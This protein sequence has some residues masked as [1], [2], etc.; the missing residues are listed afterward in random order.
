MTLRNNET[1]PG[2]E[3]GTFDPEVWPSA[4]TPLL[5]SC[6]QDTQSNSR[7]HDYDP[8][9]LEQ[10]PLHQHQNNLQGANP[11]EKKILASVNNIL[12]QLDIWS[13]SLCGFEI[14]SSLFDLG[15]FSFFLSLMLS[16]K[17]WPNP[18]GITTLLHHVTCKATGK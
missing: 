13:R 1:W 12:M 7:T 11:Q 18:L 6:N 16:H 9:Q 10:C 17:G 5:S 14:K 15:V 2:F 3:P 4:T 8:Y